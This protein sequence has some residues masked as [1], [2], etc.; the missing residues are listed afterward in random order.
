MRMAGMRSEMCLLILLRGFCILVVIR[1]DDQRIEFRTAGR[2]RTTKFEAVPQGW[3]KG[4]VFLLCLIDVHDSAQF[5]AICFE[6]FHPFPSSIYI[7]LT[8]PA[9]KKPVRVASRGYAGN[10]LRL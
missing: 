3:R 7:C 1:S 5:F 10:T 2:I 8:E 6:D 4:E 9:A